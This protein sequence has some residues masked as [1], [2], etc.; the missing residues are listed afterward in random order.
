[1]RACPHQRDTGSS[2]LQKSVA[3]TSPE[4]V[5]SQQPSAT[6]RGWPEGNAWAAEL[7]P[8]LGGP[9]LG[10]DTQG[11]RHD[12]R[13]PGSPSTPRAP[14]PWLYR[15]STNRKRALEKCPLAQLQ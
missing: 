14:D 4:S 9:L 7:I 1:M 6:S 15:E 8:R 11:G 5:Y 12:V 2:A 10:L 13:L 3:A